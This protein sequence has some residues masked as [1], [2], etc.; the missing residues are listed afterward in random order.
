MSSFRFAATICVVF[1][2]LPVGD[3]EARGTPQGAA[4]PNGVR[5]PGDAKAAVPSAVYRSAFGR[6]RLN[7]EAEV[8]AWRELN[9]NVGRVGGWRVYGREASPDAA[10]PGKPTGR[11]GPEAVSPA[12]GHQR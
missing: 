7:S 12:H 4:A 10:P 3:A 6:Y 8:G 11:E 9:D 1:G 5:D 2:V